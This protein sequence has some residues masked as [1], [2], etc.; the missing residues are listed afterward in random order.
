[1]GEKPTY[2]SHTLDRA[3]LG[4]S[5]ALYVANSGG[6]R[7]VQTGRVRITPTVHARVARNASVYFRS[8]INHIT[9]H[10]YKY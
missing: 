8:Y 4:S 10:E 5:R 3:L 9:Q 7:A 2:W 6:E 1:M